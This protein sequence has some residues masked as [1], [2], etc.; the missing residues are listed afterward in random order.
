MISLFWLTA[1]CTK[2]QLYFSWD[3]WDWSYP[4]LIS[5]M[6]SSGWYLVLVLHG[7]LLIPCPFVNRF[8]TFPCPDCYKRGACR[9]APDAVLPDFHCR[10]CLFLAKTQWLQPVFLPNAAVP[11]DERPCGFKPRQRPVLWSWGRLW[12]SA[13]PTA[14]RVAVG[15]VGWH[16]WVP[17]AAAASELVKYNWW[18]KAPNKVLWNLREVLTGC[19][20]FALLCCLN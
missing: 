14:G 4:T 6:V 20:R 19:R 12:S 16:P 1:S 11:C 18:A 7:L 9:K 10:K 8:S 2:L 17:R 5:V 15:Q 3:C 13:I